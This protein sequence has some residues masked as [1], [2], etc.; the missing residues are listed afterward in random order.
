MSHNKNKF[1]KKASYKHK[2]YSKSEDLP[3]RLNDLEIRGE[4]GMHKY[5]FI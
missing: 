2:A 3:T 1:R 5:C 4:S